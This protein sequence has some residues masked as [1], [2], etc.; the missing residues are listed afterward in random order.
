MSEK[1]TSEARAAT[2]E[3]IP[4][5]EPWLAVSSLSLIPTVGLFVLPEAAMIPM[6]IAMAVLMGTGIAMFLRA[7]RSKKD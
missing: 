6:W 7:E 5:M 4:R 3:D 2:R 1:K